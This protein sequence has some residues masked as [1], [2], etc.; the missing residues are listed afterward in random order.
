MKAAIIED[1]LSIIN[2]V[3]I[4][5]EFRWPDVRLVSAMTGL[6]GVELVRKE[7]PDV[8]ILDINL[9]DISGFEVLKKIRQFSDVPVIVL[10][11]RSDDSDVL[12]GLETGA[13]D[14]ITKPFNYLTLLA[15]VKAV[16]R[17]TDRAEIKLERNTSINSRLNI[18]FVNQKVRVDNQPVKL[19]PVE[20][21]LLL[22]LVKHK[23]QVVTYKDI[24]AVVWGK[25][26][27]QD[28]ENIRIYVRRLRK[29]LG[30]I[31]PQMLINQHGSGYMLK[32]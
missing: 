25:D 14:Y 11:V 5:F 10:T 20:Y 2:A 32:S 28:T 23:N 4:A 16:L 1:D 8:L 13:D 24:M 19:T 12:K 6:E 30:D 3:N 7:S 22:L 17:R 21:Q 15:R 29:K 31:P 26:D 18:D 9:P 27:W